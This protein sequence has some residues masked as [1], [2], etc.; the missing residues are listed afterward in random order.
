MATPADVK[1]TMAAAAQNGAAQA[2][3]IAEDGVAQARAAVEKTMETA[4]KAATDLIKATEEAVELGRGNFEAV[5]KAS[6]LYVTGV[7]DLTRQTAA[8]FQ[9]YSDQ[10]IE[11]VKTMSSMK[12]LKEATD[13]QATYS[14][15]SFERAMADASKIQEATIKLAETAFEPI[16]SRMNI[17]VEK[18]T[19][20]LAA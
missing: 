7:Q 14:R 6:Q 3:Q 20:P 4:N 15:S 5:S 2:K 17:I 19:K 13:F 10:A 1:K 8:M 11:A 18:M 9:A 12:S 16:S